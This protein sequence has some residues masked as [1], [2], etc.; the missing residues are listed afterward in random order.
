LTT[1]ILAV[2]TGIGVLLFGSLPWGALLAP[3]NLRFGNLVP[4]AIAP[5]AA[6]LCAYF[7]FLG[8]RWGARESAAWRREQLRANPV[9]ASLWGPALAAG[10]LGFGAL[11][12]FLAVMGRVVALPTSAPLTAPPGMPA[13]TAFL[14]LVMSSIVAG[15]TEEAAFRGYMQSPV[16]RRYGLVPAIL[17]NGTMFGLLHFPNHPSAVLQMLPYYVAVAAV[18]GGLT[19]AANSILP[20]LVLHAGGDVWSLGRLW[21]TGRPEWQLSATAPA[22]IRDT[23]IDALFIMAAA[24][25]AVLTALTIVALRAVHRMRVDLQGSEGAAINR[26][27]RL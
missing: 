7:T 9:A 25:C 2:V 12:A 4:W 18:Y 6:Y 24:G 22:L 20:A 21:I 8:G 5:M 10:L 23:G 11:L 17:V 27:V 1:I 14:L 13:I 15:V 26:T 3:A 16:E 19:W